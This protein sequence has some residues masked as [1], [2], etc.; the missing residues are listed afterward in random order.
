M[1]E[2][3]GKTSSTLGASSLK[4]F[5]TVCCSHSFSE[6]VFLVSLSLL[7]L[8]C[9]LHGTAPPCLITNVLLVHSNDHTKA[10]YIIYYFFE[11]VKTFLRNFAN[12]NL[13][14]KSY[15][16]RKLPKSYRACCRNVQRIHPVIHRYL[17]GV[18]TLGNGRF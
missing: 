3:I 11:F 6:T 8:I 10:E 12:F 2:L 9:S 16:A 15:V 18:V 17:N 13:N 1:T 4:N 7:R 14:A 5:S